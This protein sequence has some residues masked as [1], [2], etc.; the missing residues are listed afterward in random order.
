MVLLYHCQGLIKPVASQSLSFGGK[1]AYYVKVRYH[2]ENIHRL[3]CPETTG[4]STNK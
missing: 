2:H 4:S 3:N 1:D